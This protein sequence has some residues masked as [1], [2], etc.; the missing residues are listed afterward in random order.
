MVREIGRKHHFR[1]FDVLPFSAEDIRKFTDNL[2][3]LL[4]EQQ[5]VVETIKVYAHNSF[6]APKFKEAAL[7]NC[8]F[9]ILSIVHC[10]VHGGHQRQLKEQENDI[11]SKLQKLNEN[12]ATCSETKKN[13]KKQIVSALHQY[14][15]WSHRIVAHRIAAHMGKRFHR[16]PSSSG[17]I[18]TQN[19][20]M[21]S[22]LRLLSWKHSKIDLGLR[23]VVLE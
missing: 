13:A 3:S 9:I 11:N 18:S 21:A 5:S 17:S 8:S 10:L 20:S 2:K 19:S 16:I 12:I 7:F 4:C 23:W 15:T 22:K 14:S 1:G 6:Y